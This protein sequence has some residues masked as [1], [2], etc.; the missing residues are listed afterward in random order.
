MI[1]VGITLVVLGFVLLFIS[2]WVGAPLLVV[3]LA[4]SA[5]WFAG[6]GRTARGERPTRL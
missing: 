1:G 2:P 6:F 3:G 5:L 4:L